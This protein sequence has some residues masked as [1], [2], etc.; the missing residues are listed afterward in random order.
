MPGKSAD[1]IVTG[2]VP[3]FVAVPCM[4][5]P[6]RQKYKMVPRQDSSSVSSMKKRGDQGF[7]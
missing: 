4:F 3:L 6:R 1:S 5:I 7:M 2:P